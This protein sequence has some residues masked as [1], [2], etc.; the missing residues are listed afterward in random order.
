ML[1]LL[2]HFFYISFVPSL[3]TKKSRPSIMII[4]IHLMHIIIVSKLHDQASEL[5]RGMKVITT[6]LAPPGQGII[7]QVTCPVCPVTGDFIPLCFAFFLEISTRKMDLEPFH[8]LPFSTN[9]LCFYMFSFQ[10]LVFSFIISHSC[11]Y[12]LHQSI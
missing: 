6:D 2:P 7:L 5:R 1:F 12:N 8:S 4:I 9:C 3:D 10:I 11:S